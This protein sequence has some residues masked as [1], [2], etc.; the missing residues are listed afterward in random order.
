ML[1]M[2]STL[3]IYSYIYWLSYLVVC[4]V[5]YFVGLFKFFLLYFVFICDKKW[6]RSLKCK[7]HVIILLKVDV[8]AAGSPTV[9]S[10][11]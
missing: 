9:P 3:F 10:T 6:D 11:S 8:T 7:V 1:F 5:F 2:Y 4:Y